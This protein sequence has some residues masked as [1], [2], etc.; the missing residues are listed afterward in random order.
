MEKTND[1]R[2]IQKVKMTALPSNYNPKLVDYNCVILYVECECHHEKRSMKN[3]MEGIST[4][5]T[6]Q[7]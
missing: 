7:Q 1:T 4:T 2:A 3:S 6:K 5:A